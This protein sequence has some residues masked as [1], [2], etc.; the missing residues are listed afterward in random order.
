MRDSLSEGGWI[1]STEDRN[2]SLIGLK[3]LFS[4]VFWGLNRPE[5]CLINMFNIKWVELLLV[6]TLLEILRRYLK[7]GHKFALK[8]GHKFE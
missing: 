6:C 5:S 8:K 4:Q 1:F 2:E 3:G 7:S